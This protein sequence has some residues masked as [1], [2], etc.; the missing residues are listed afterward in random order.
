MKADTPLLPEPFYKADGIT[1][2]HGDCRAILPLLPRGDVVIADPPYGETRLEWD[3]W[4]V[5]WPAFCTSI[6]NSL[7]CFGSFRMFWKMRGEFDSWKLS[8]DVVWEKH[9]GSSLHADRFRRVHEHVVQFY[10]GSWGDVHKR[11][12]SEPS[13]R[14]GGRMM[15]RRKPEHFGQVDP[16]G[17]YE[18]SGQRLTRSVMKVP[19]CHGYAVNETQKPEAL[20]ETILRYSAPAGGLV[21][22]P[23]A[24]S[25]TDLVVARR[26]GLRAIAIEKRESQCIAIV[27]RL[28]S[29]LSLVE[30]CS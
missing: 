1:L 12:P 6:A 5:G 30:G 14:L 28:T 27:K 7:W 11:P 29:E 18:Y 17:M 26:L 10:R 4:P 24:G 23:F 8:Q 2:Y 20:V 3:K 19:S 13:S 9:N 16:V 25:G 21:I 22:I 15:R